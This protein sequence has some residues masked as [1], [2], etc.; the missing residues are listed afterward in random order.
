MSPSFLAYTLIFIADY[1]ARARLSTDFYL[2]FSTFPH[3]EVFLFFISLLLCHTSVFRPKDVI[4]LLTGL[5]IDLV[6]Y[7]TR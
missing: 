3:C 7:P 4:Y 5:T 1:I 2:F 6:S